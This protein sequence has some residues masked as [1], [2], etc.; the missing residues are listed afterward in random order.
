[1]SNIHKISLNWKENREKSR[2]LA[3]NEEEINHAEDVWQK[4][5]DIS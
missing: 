4:M 1:M 3:M 5:V 2:R